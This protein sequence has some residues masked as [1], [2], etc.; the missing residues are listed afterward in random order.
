MFKYYINVPMNEKGLEEFET[1]AED[2]PNVYSVEL[3]KDEYVVLSAANGLFKEYYK[4]F[5]IIIDVCEEEDIDI[6]EIDQ[7][8]EITKQYL[9]KA[10]NAAEK[11]GV[12]KVMQALEMGKEAGYYVEFNFFLSGE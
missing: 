9:T 12:E 11:S 4:A 5:G 7:A 3:T 2:T 1:F 10:K 6:D 8:I